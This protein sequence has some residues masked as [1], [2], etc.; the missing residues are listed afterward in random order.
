MECARREH[1][2]GTNSALSG[3]PRRSTVAWFDSIGI[4]D[5]GCVGGKNASLGEM[6][7]RL[8]GQGV[9][10]PNGFATTADAYRA[11]LRHNHLDDRI[12]DLLA[13]W[14]RV[15]VDDLATRTKA[16]RSLILA[17]NSPKSSSPR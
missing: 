14:D 17:G 10:V 16:I 9:R 6:Y 11:F 12:S 2:M 15:D 13:G 3:A 4:D 8:A 1:T 5:V 7:Q